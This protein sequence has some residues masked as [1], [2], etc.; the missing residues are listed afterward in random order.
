[1]YGVDATS[2]L[3]ANLNACLVVVSLDGVTHHVNSLWSS[4]NLLFTCGC[5]DVICAGIHS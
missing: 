3:Q 2:W 5:L 1:M 4:G